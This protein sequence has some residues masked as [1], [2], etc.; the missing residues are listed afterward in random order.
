MRPEVQLHR[1]IMDVKER[2]V[3]LLIMRLKLSTFLCT[4]SISLD[5]LVKHYWHFLGRKRNYC[6]LVIA[7]T[8]GRGVLIAPVIF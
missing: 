2:W 7:V 8:V 1:D 4:F 5:S 6:S 3:R